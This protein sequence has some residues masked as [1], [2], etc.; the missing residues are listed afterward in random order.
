MYKAILLLFVLVSLE[1]GTTGK[2]LDGI[3]TTKGGIS[4]PGGRQ[5]AHGGGRILRNLQRKGYKRIGLRGG[6]EL[7][8]ELA[9][10][11]AYYK[12]WS[13][14]RDREEGKLRRSVQNIARHCPIIFAI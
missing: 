3:V 5:T 7:E 8:D 2:V 4:G 10:P 12:V 9:D 1:T 14:S 11:D 13:P 6:G